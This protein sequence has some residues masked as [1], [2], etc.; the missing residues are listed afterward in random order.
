MERKQSRS[1][2][3]MNT[4]SSSGNDARGGGSGLGEGAP[5]S[6]WLAWSRRRRRRAAVAPAVSIGAWDGT[7][8]SGFLGV[9][10][11]CPSAHG[12]EAAGR[13]LVAGPTTPSVLALA[14]G[15]EP[16]A[17]RRGEGGAWTARHRHASSVHAL[18][19]RASCGGD[20][21][22]R[23]MHRGGSHASWLVHALTYG[24]TVEQQFLL[25]SLFVSGCHVWSLAVNLSRS[26][27]CPDRQ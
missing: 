3:R 4:G 20:V 13:S 10:G 5:Q 1:T 12:E 24:H 2:K 17:L 15:V 7:I 8:C 22:I 18:A 14:G 19:L 11:S 26:Q 27:R 23:R 9:C 25:S 6:R 21:R 16:W